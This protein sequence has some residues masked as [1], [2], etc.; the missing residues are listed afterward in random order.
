MGPKHVPNT[1]TKTHWIFEHL[2]FIDTR[3]RLLYVEQIWVLIRLGGLTA[4]KDSNSLSL[5]YYILFV[6]ETTTNHF[7][8]FQG[9]WTHHN[10]QEGEYHEWWG[11]LRAFLRDCFDKTRVQLN[12]ITA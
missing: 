4:V 11:T 12:A 6:D 5:Q 1:P 3:A 10:D 9:M 7:A 8:Q 2:R